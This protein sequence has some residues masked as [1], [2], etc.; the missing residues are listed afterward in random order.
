MIAVLSF[1]NLKLARHNRVILRIERHK[2]RLEMEA[3]EEKRAPTDLA[4]LTSPDL[5]YR[6][7]PVPFL[8]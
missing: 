8:F 2:A 5:L 1:D 3:V 6:M 4:F 7:D